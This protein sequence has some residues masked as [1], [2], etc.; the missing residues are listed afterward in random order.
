MLKRAWQPTDR[1]P[2]TRGLVTHFLGE[3][4]CKWCDQQGF[5]FQNTQTAHITVTTHTPTHTHT[6]PTKK[7]VEFSGA[8]LVK[9]P[10]ANAANTGLIPSGPWARVLWLR[11]PRHLRAHAQPKRS[12]HR[13]RPAHWNWSRPGSPDPEK[14]RAQQQRPSTTR[15]K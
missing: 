2:H 1:K 7:W 13:E 3:N 4:I 15:N 8:P 9:D 6:P 10:P 12:R 14:A 5:N 11:K